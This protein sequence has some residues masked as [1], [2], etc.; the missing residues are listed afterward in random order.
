MQ[1]AVWRSRLA[2]HARFSQWEKAKDEITDIR[3]VY[4]AALRAIGPLNVNDGLGNI[5]KIS[6]KVFEKTIGICK[7][8]EFP[9]RASM[10]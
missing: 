10:R 7:K 3:P 8:M 6:E 5:D 1:I 4:L 2:R 9:E